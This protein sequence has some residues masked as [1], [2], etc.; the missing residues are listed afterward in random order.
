MNFSA[1]DAG[2]VDTRTVDYLSLD[3]IS[4]VL[5]A[6]QTRYAAN[7][8]CTVKLTCVESSLSV[9]EYC[10]RFRGIKIVITALKHRRAAARKEMRRRGK[11][12]G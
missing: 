7:Q 1:A 8:V 10:L 6:T 5:D 3:R 2:D 9:P 12:R 11:E 4:P